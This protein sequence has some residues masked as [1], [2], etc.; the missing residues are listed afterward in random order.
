MVMRYEKDWLDVLELVDCERC[1]T[2]SVQDTYNP[3]KN[4][5]RLAHAATERNDVRLSLLSLEWQARLDQAVLL[6][7]VVFNRP[8]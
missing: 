8:H 5:L 7:S 4:T 1:L 6:Y 2:V 3:E